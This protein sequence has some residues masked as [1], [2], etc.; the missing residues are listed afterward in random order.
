MRVAATEAKNRFGS[1]CSHAKR[2]PV[3]VEK[4]VQLDSVILSVEGYG[5]LRRPVDKGAR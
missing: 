5:T 2:G 1:L 3:F 4:S